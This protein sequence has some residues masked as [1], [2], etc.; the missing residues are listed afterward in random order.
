MLYV[1]ARMLSAPHHHPHSARSTDPSNPSI[2]CC[3]VLLPL[4]PSATKHAYT[5][6]T[7]LPLVSLCASRLCATREGGLN[8]WE[9]GRP[10]PA[11]DCSAA[12]ASPLYC[13]QPHPLS[14]RAKGRRK[15]GDRASRCH[16]CRF[17][18][19]RRPPAG[20][21]AGRRSLALVR[22]LPPLPFSPL[23][24][25]SLPF[26]YVCFCAHTHTLNPISTAAPTHAVME[27]DE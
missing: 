24:R 11:L 1:E 14:G 22:R 9:E 21:Q 25:V 15:Q 12:G 7:N 2:A 27:S 17:L 8:P 18:S 20:F 26:L 19:N 5:K 16:N 4:S 23:A 13:I 3:A 10:P 6:E